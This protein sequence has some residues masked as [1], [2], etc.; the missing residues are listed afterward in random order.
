MFQ[1][2]D[3]LDQFEAILSAFTFII[4]LGTCVLFGWLIKRLSSKAIRDE[5]RPAL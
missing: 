4:S 5:F 1:G 3:D 2:S